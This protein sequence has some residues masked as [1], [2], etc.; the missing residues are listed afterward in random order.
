MFIPNHFSAPS[1]EA[2]EALIRTFP[3]ANL[4]TPCVDEPLGWA[5]NP[6]P[7]GL[8]E[9]LASGSRLWAHTARANPLWKSLAD[10]PQAMVI[11]N[12]PSAYITPNAY[13]SKQATHRVVPTYNYTTVQLTGQLTVHHDAA[14]KQD[15][16]KRLTEHH[17]RDQVVPWSVNDAPAD[18]LEAMLK[19]IV[20]LEFTVQTIQAK[21]KVSQ[22]RP[23]ADQAGVIA[24]LES[25]E[26]SPAA[27]QMAALVRRASS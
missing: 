23:A 11:F 10:Q 7:M 22:N 8:F 1:T 2:I 20:G 3:L 18:Y 13:P 14:V 12:G 15:I 24:D 25:R 6:I 17:E 5:I 16:V 19:A 4:L 21:W 9:P 26:E 27:T